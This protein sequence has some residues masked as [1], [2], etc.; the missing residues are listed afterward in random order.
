MKK[1]VIR[2][3]TKEDCQNM[4]DLLSGKSRYKFHVK[5]H[6]YTGRKY[7]LTIGTL[8]NCD[9]QERFNNEVIKTLIRVIR[10]MQR[11]CVGYDGFN[12]DEE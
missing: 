3:L 1:M 2:G 9:L 6:N 12:D 8:R 7:E 10:K 4:E 5:Y 11:H